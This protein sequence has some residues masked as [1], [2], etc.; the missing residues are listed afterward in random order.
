MELDVAV[1]VGVNEGDHSV[2][3]AV[4][5]IGG[6]ERRRGDGA[7]KVVFANLVIAV[8]VE[9]I[10]GLEEVDW[11]RTEAVVEGASVVLIWGD[12]VLGVSFDPFW[13]PPSY[14]DAKQDV[15]Y[16]FG[17]VDE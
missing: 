9:D 10:E 8:G 14:D 7:A 6:G 1:V 5:V 17:S 12:Q 15:T 13:I 4:V 2:D 11:R 16:W 3:E